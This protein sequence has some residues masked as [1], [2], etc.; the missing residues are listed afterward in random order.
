MYCTLLTSSWANMI[1]HCF[2]ACMPLTRQPMQS[3]TQVP[4]G[5][6]YSPQTVLLLL[7][8]RS[9]LIS[10]TVVCEG[11]KTMLVI[12]APCTATYS[13]ARLK[14][15]LA[16]HRHHHHP[17]PQ[18][19]ATSQSHRRRRRWRALLIRAGRNME[20]HAVHKSSSG[21]G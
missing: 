12:A 7:P 16:A 13:A 5:P 14:S 17:Q 19:R 4:T 11:M 9:G 20:Q 2:Q 10:R 18:A 1:I 8:Y 6:A 3:Q 21:V 15:F